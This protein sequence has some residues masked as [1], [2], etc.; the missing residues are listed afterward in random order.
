[1]LKE[2]TLFGEVDKVE[3]AIKR[4][5]NFEPTEGYYLAFSGGKDSVVIKEL[6]IMSRVKFDAHYSMTT[7]D[8]PDVV[9]FIKTKHSDVK[10]ERPA[11]PLLK[12]LETNGFPSRIARWCCEEYKENGGRNRLIV[13]GVR[14]AES[15]K[16]RSRQLNE[17]CRL[18]PDKRFLNVIIDWTEDD[19][20]SFIRARNLPYCS[21]YD[22]GFSRIG[23]LM[24]P[25]APT[26]LRV[27]ESEMYPAMTRAF[28]RAFERL[29][30]K[31]K[32]GG[33][34]KMTVKFKN[35]REMFDWWLHTDFGP[36]EV[37]DVDNKMFDN[38]V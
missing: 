22:K 33:K 36:V 12:R 37:E 27:K 1:M 19:V 29:Y 4:L 10:F 3:I 20:W 21:L 5:Q 11:M 9:R 30:A 2:Q 26:R 13:T 28:I 34:S 17:S 23:C 38:F 31:R 35:G 8:P 25:M 7:I 24:C 14:A 6:A 15:A 32:A 16:R 18:H